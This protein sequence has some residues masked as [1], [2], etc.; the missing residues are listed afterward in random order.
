[1][2]ILK[3][4]LVIVLLGVL[5]AGLLT[6]YEELPPPKEPVLLLPTFGEA[7]DLS[8]NGFE[9][10]SSRFKAV[11]DAGLAAGATPEQIL[12]AVY[13]VYRIGCYTYFTA[14]YRAERSYGGG[15]GGIP[16]GTV[17]GYMDVF[18][19][20]FKI[21]S[22]DSDEPYTYYG[23]YESFSQLS[24]VKGPK[25][26][27]VMEPIVAA[28]IT[29]AEKECDAPEGMTKW[30][31]IKGSA[32]LNHEGGTATF[33]ERNIS[34]K[35][36]ATIAAETAADIAA[37][38]KRSYDESWYDE[39]GLSAPEKTQHTM[40]KNTMDPASL[41]IEKDVDKNGVAFYR[42]KFDI[43]CN[44]ES[45]GFEAQSIKNTAD[46]IKSIAYSYLKVEMEVYESGYLRRWS[47][48]ESWIGTLLSFQGS[49]ASDSNTYISYDKDVVEQG[50]RD[51]WFGDYPLL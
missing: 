25:S 5:G 28:A 36:R 4:L 23:Y 20:S 26:V 29:S 2:K 49:T 22:E 15:Y 27:L 50:I 14:P 32:V 46:I 38:K 13:A 10:Y 40:N 18:N 39:Y 48:K 42:V 35:S 34:F 8:V 17:G 24:E 1:M 37:N 44:E 43:I 21:H 30:N 51:L 47:S 11:A 9:D 19:R 31:G 7:P 12:E 41:A 16:D 45:T 33:P 3:V 6:A